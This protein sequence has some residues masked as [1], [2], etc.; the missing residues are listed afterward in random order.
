[1]TLENGDVCDVG[2]CLHSPPCK[3]N[4]GFAVAFGDAAHFRITPDICHYYSR[5]VTSSRVVRVKAN[6]TGFPSSSRNRR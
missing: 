2:G 4:P 5:N 1:M 6:D 3:G